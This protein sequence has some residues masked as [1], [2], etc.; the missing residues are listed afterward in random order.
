MSY[1]YKI[2]KEKRLVT[3]SIWDNVDKVSVLKFRREIQAD[4]DFSSDFNQLA[5]Y[6]PNTKLDVTSQEVD[7][8]RIG[9]PFSAASRRAFVAHSD[10]LYGYARMY[11]SLMEASGFDNIKV[12]RN[13]EEAVMWIEGAE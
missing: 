3:V 2:D 8:L 7:E 11:S 5:E 13:M 1:S 10:L 4:P 9:D 6:Q 12:F